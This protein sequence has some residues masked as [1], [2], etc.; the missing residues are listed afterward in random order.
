MDNDK[1][2]TEKRRGEITGAG[3]S[4]TEK[5]SILGEMWTL[6]EEGKT[7]E[8]VLGQSETG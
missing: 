4:S 5:Q 3:E 1:R 8:E 7:V 6:Q 2:R